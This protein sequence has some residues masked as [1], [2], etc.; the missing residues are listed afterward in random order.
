MLVTRL[1]VWT[2]SLNTDAWAYTAWAKAILRGERPVFD[3]LPTT[4]K[5]LAIALAAVA[6][7]IDVERVFGVVVAVALAAIATA[8][9]TVGMREGGTVAGV[10]SVT[11][12]ACLPHL[13]A[14]IVFGTVDA[15]SAALLVGA[16]AVAGRARLACLILAGLLRPEAWV[17][18]GMVGA[19]QAGG[20]TMRR[21]VAGVAYGLLPAALWSA[22]D[23]VLSDDPLASL[24]QAGR[25]LDDFREAGFRAP[26]WLSVPGSVIEVVSTQTGA[27]VAIAGVF[28]LTV[29]TWTRRRAG[30]LDPLLPATAVVWTL[31]PAIEMHSVPVPGRYF[32]PA[33]ALLALGCGLLAGQATRGTSALPAVG[34]AAAIAALIASAATMDYPA[35]A[36][37]AQLAA[38]ISASVPAI[39]RAL[40]CGRVRVMNPQGA[41]TE[42]GRIYV[43]EL[44]ARTGHS[45]RRFGSIGHNFGAV[46]RVRGSAGPL[47]PWPQVSTPIGTLALDPDR[48]P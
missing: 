40:A 34:A 18:S 48:C 32:L 38:A 14:F 4:P 22:T 41:A 36:R 7:P 25:I 44:A 20:S 45:V 17:L 23:L 37:S 35:G 19:I 31:G 12:F 11:A 46:L 27:L 42:G 16:L 39:D 15:V 47:P 8:L 26:S 30:T 2:P 10:V 5:P 3:Y 21:V 9:F 28:G 1:L 6:S 24:H 33:A 43:S 29:H 13:N